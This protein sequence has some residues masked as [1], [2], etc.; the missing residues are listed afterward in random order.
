M[1][2]EFRKQVINVIPMAFLI[3]NDVP[4][5]TGPTEQCDV[6]QAVRDLTAA[7]RSALNR[8][9]AAE[10]MRDELLAALETLLRPY[11]V[12][13]VAIAHTMGDLRGPDFVEAVIAA[14]NAIVKARSQ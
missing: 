8:C 12:A 4:G 10:A 1:N 3:R 6:V 5:A 7:G 11:G 2:A 14:R 9:L 13:D